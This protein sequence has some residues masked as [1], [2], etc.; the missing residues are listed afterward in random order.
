V[1]KALQ[2]LSVVVCANSQTD[3]CRPFGHGR[4]SDTLDEEASTLKLVRESDGSSGVADE[5]GDDRSFADDPTSD[6]A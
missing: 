1:K 4:R 6:G 3:A 2:C 5:P